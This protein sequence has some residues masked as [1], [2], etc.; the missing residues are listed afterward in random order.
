VDQNSVAKADRIVMR[1]THLAVKG[2]LGFK[3]P[4]EF[5]AAQQL[6]KRATHIFT[7]PRL[8]ERLPTADPK[9]VAAP[10]PA[11]SLA[12]LSCSTWPCDCC[13]RPPKSNRSHRPAQADKAPDKENPPL[14]LGL[15]QTKDEWFER[16][17]SRAAVRVEEHAGSVDPAY[18]AEDSERE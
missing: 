15:H 8:A 13:P 14:R 16:L 11:F 9:S 5:A 12:P 10:I 18:L 4:V 7:A 17:H 6:Q 1:C 3:I 2:K